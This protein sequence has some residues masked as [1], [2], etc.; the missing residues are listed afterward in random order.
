MTE[1]A[2]PALEPKPTEYLQIWAE[3][4]SQALGQ[5][6]GSPALCS[7]ETEAPTDLPT[8][9]EGDLWAIVAAAGGL[10]GEMRVRLSPAVTLRLAQTFLNEALAPDAPLIP[11][12][13]KAVIE[14]LR[15]ISGSVA[16][17]AKT[18]WG[19]IQLSVE[20]APTAPSW[21]P[22]ETVWLRAGGEGAAGMT[23]EI[24]LSAALAAELHSAKSRVAK[25]SPD[26]A[27]TTAPPAPSDQIFGA[28]D[29]LM[30]VQLAVSMRFG[31]RRLLLSEVLDLSPGAVIELDRRI[32]EPVDLL[33]DGRVVAHGEVVVIEGNFGLR[34]TD[35][36]PISQPAARQ[37][38]VS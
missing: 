17:A 30:D 1:A 10:R 24:S 38:G 32:Q 36:F 33:L 28:L 35:I 14:L 22:A 23:L 20:L 15:K 3:S 13:C 29:L 12:H 2:A 19:E 18:K 37:D 6:T 11:D 34:V 25:L 5:M 21:P 27:T 26:P 8:A 31:S 9:A 7:L 4:L 16:S